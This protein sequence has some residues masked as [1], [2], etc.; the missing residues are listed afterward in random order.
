[1]GLAAPASPLLDLRDIPRAVK[2]LE[3]LGLRVRPGLHL[4]R[5]T[6]FLAGTDQERAGDLNALF[7]DPEVRAVFALRGGYG[8]GRLLELLDWEAVRANPKVVVGHSDLTALLTALHQRTGLVTFWGPLAGYDLGRHPRPFKLRWLREVTFRAPDQLSLPRGTHRWRTLAGGTAEGR[9]TGGNLSLICSLMGTPWELDTTGRL[10]FFEDVDEDPYRLDRML[11]QLALA[12][13]LAAAA[14]I[15][16]GWCVNCESSGR[17]RRSFTLRQVLED[18]LA[19]LGV[20]VVYG[21]PIGHE[22][23]KITLPLGVRARLEA[24][25]QRL[26]LLESPVS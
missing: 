8:S 7:A 9:L 1:M 14:G 6:G 13:K 11:G 25:S 2:A 17:M 15:V 23:D 4:R 16:V 26:T 19:G 3:G 20:P 22:P 18:R 12:G 5:R 24:D 10:L 21:A